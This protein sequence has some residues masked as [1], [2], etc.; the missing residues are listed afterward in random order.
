MKAP[1]ITLIALYCLSLGITM[2]RHGQERVEKPNFFISLIS[3][4]IQ[5]GI[6]IWGGFFS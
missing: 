3:A 2:S 6:L 5:I 1:Q 4:G